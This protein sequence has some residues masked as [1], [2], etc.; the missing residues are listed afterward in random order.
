MLLNSKKSLNCTT[1]TLK[2]FYDMT[3][4]KSVESAYPINS[5]KLEVILQKSYAGFLLVK[6]PRQLAPRLE[7]IP[8]DKTAN[9]GNNRT[10]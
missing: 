5:L 9:Q 8:P 6:I 3:K 10:S 7:I 2:C 4:R 1:L